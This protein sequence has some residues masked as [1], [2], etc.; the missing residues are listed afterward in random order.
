M[1]DTSR[2]QDIVRLGEALGLTRSNPDYYALELG[3][4]VLGGGFYATRLYHD[5]R[6]NGGL[7]YNV[8][9]TFEVGKSRGLYVVRYACEP[10]NVFE[11]RA[12]VERDLQEM[13]TT[14]VT[15]SELRQAT[16]MLLREVPLSESS[17]GR[18]AA[19][20]ISRTTEGLPLDE[21]TLAA[22]RYLR[23]TAADVKAAFGKWLRV[24][25][26]VQVTEGPTPQL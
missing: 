25:D 8:S 3:N 1:P 10:R 2:V 23:L 7:V 18:I 21:P 4:H 12:I 16:A 20:L 13:Q 14:P 9:S 26:L 22:R 15:A 6:E 17:V 24:S 5:L 19:A 11:A